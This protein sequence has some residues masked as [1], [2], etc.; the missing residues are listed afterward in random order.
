M[1]ILARADRG[2]PL[3]S[4]EKRVASMFEKVMFASLPSYLAARIDQRHFPAKKEEPYGWDSTHPWFAYC[5][6]TVRPKL[7]VEVGTWLGASAVHMASLCKQHG[8]DTKIICVDTWLGASEHYSNPTWSATLDFEY[9]YPRLYHA[10]LRNV[11]AS[12]HFGTIL[13]LPLDA[14]SAAEVLI[15]QGL[16]ADLVYIDAG[17]G[18]D[19]CLSDLRNYANV[20]RDDG[21]ILG[22]D[23]RGDEVARAV[24]AF[25]VAQPD[26]RLYVRDNK[27]LL[28][29]RD[30]ADLA[31]Y[32]TAARAVN[33]SD[34]SYQSFTFDRTRGGFKRLRDLSLRKLISLKMR[35][36]WS[37]FIDALERD[38]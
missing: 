8:I 1:R 29:R 14:T 2:E 27:Y 20:V 38:V 31:D 7:I 36:K 3:M 15:A 19:A 18:F 26:W 33:P 24:A 17:H 10:F 4:A 5:V 23:F 37:G 35:G 28:C 13:P 32:K 9:G 22:D 11:I 6:S 30:L 25:V 16:K 21:V 34:A 12:G